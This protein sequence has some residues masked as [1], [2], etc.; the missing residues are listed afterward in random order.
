MG[1]FEPFRALGYITDGTPFAVQRRGMETFITLSTGKSWQIYNCAKL[2][3]VLA[4]PELVKK[5]RALASWRDFTFV[6]SGCDIVVFKRAHQVATWS[7]HKA[8]VAFLLLFGKHILSLDLQGSLLIWTAVELDPNKALVGQIQLG[9]KFYPSCIMHPDTYLNKVIVGSEE[10][11]LQLWNINT[12]K[13]LYEFKGWASSIRCCVSSPA[14]DVVG[15]GCA[16]GK[17]HVHN[18]RFD[19]EVVTFTHTTRG[20]V[21]ALAFR[22]DG[23]PLLA[24]G[25][26]SGV[27]SVW[28]LEKKRLHSVIKD[29]HYSSICSLYFFANEPVLMSSSTDNSIKMWIF[30]TSDGEAR[31]LRFRSG[32]SA[33]PTCIRY[34]GKGRHILSAGQDRAFRFFSVIQDQ[35]SRE[36]S[37]GH[38]VK[39]AKKLK[40]KEEEIKLPP[41]I[42]FEAAEI[43]ERDWCNV[44][45]CHLDDPC[46][47]TW[48]LQNFVIGEHILRPSCEV[49]T[50]VKACS[51]STCGNFAV[52]GTEGGWIER[53]NLQSGFSRGSYIDIGEEEPC[54]H[55]GAVVGL[56]C[57]AMNALLISG[58]YNGDIKIWDFKGRELKFRWEVGAPLVKIVYHAGNG[59]LATAADDM[60]LRLYDV[61]AVRIVRKFVGHMDRVTDL[62]FSEDGKWLLSSSMDGTI[63]I[64][65][66][67]SSR[68]LDAIHVDAAPT[69][70]SISPNMDMLATTH[71][72]KN[73]IYLWANRM[74]Y[75]GAEDIESFISGEQ[76]VNVPMPTVSSRK[77]SEDSEDTEEDTLVKD[78]AI[79]KLG[80]SN[81]LIGNLCSAQLTPGLVTLAMLPKTQWQSLVNLDIIKMRNKP[82]EPPKKPEKAPF[83]LQSLSTLSGERIFVHNSVTDSGDQNEAEKVITAAQS[84]NKNEG[85]SAFMKLLHSCMETGDFA[86]VTDYL[87][88]LSPSAVDLE[89]RMLQIIDN[90]NITET[91][92]AVELKGI[93]MLLDYFVSE[94]FCNNNF[95]FVQA[96]IRLFLKI[97]GETIRRQIS[98]QEK[99][100]QLLE[101]QSSTWQRLD[102]NFQNTR[103]MITFLSN[104]QF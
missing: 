90:E 92:H 91:E 42:A 99:A 104:S 70:L 15:I 2:N 97:H 82:I 1:I 37:Q 64:W 57:E 45:T 81:S 93:G 53:F 66:V 68:Q 63:R 9:E 56:A 89:L 40:L 77:D 38:V 47:Y 33:P 21:T 24:A 6:A 25:G 94:V 23:Q 39:R 65:D 22:T 31:L 54:G 14:L 12:Q 79:K 80:T 61:T 13:K 43:R 36:L 102:T 101:L 87:K 11:T 73:G 41:V 75:S 88:S 4:G 26:S 71:V 76:V 18:L 29:A 50:A 5:I 98:L 49:P 30:D 52:I 69:A 95:E 44:V 55:H 19:E 67:I 27:I 84:G 58:G 85:F 32:H 74:M 10:G 20:A 3:L 16:D 83:F 103:C 100:R 59:L 60:I 35:Q 51:I 72:D 8:K 48:R 7:G 62:C 96:L 78:Q 17:I 34:Y 28:N 86:S 46:A